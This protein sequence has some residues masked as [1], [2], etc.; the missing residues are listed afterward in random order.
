MQQQALQNQLQSSSI[1]R[2]I[3][4][5]QGNSRRTSSRHQ[6]FLSSQQHAPAKAKGIQSFSENVSQDRQMSNR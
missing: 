5:S 4:Q 3:L 6:E 1:S 2:Q